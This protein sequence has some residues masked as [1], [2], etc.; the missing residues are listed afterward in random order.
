VNDVAV[1]A[2]HTWLVATGHGV[3]KTT[4]AGR[5][6]QRPALGPRVRVTALA[7]SPHEEGLVLAATPIGVFRSLDGGDR[8]ILAARG[9]AD[10]Q[11]HHL[12]FLPTDPAVVFAATSKGLFRSGD[13]GESWGRVTGGVPFTDITGLALHP[14]GRTVYVSDFTWG[15][16]FR[17]QDGG[18]SWSRLPSSGL[19]TDR[20]WAI[21]LDP[22]SPDKLLAATPSG[23]LHLL[24][25]AAPAAAVSSGSQP[26]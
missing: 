3:L 4:D 16:V 17:T 1:L 20:V 9:P 10:A 15:G 5:R 19:V 14:D 18:R 11:T 13:R 22:E 26:D 8:W 6:W 2:E 24:E 23:G 25:G 12:A 7:V 21:A